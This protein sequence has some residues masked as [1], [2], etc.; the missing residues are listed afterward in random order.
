MNWNTETVISWIIIN[1]VLGVVWMVLDRK[2][3]ES[4]FRFGYNFSHRDPLPQGEVGFLYG[5]EGFESRFRRICWI[6]VVQFLVFWW[7]S[8]ETFMTYF[9]F[10][11]L[12]VPATYVGVY[13]LG[14]YAGSPFEVVD[15]YKRGEIS[16]APYITSL[17]DFAGRC[18]S[19][20][21][22]YLPSFRSAV[23]EN[24][25]EVHPEV[26]APPEPKVDPREAIRKFTGEPKE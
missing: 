22:D 10:F 23:K 8:H 11:I 20:I 19:F 6:A 17:K 18:W 14:Q 26:V 5:H 21:S 24:V 16:L 7:Y 1:V 12:S 25:V 13:L 2:F 9:L 15:K 4:I 3:G